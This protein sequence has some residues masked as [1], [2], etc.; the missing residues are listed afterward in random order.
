[1]E[2]RLNN[3]E[4]AIPGPRVV[5]L[6][7]VRCEDNTA[8][9]AEEDEEHDSLSVSGSLEEGTTTAE[10]AD[11]VTL[12]EERVNPETQEEGMGQ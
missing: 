2:L 8:H 7:L 4:F 1:M 10:N 3:W 11:P 12:Q 6:D 9:T 5:Y